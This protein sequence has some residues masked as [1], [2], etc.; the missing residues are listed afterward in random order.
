MTEMDRN[1]RTWYRSRCSVSVVERILHLTF[2]TCLISD[3]IESY[4]TL[5]YLLYLWLVCHLKQ[6]R[7]HVNGEWLKRTSKLS[8]Y[9]TGAPSIYVLTG[10]HF[11]AGASLH[12]LYGPVLS[13]AER[14][15]YTTSCITK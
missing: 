4:Q 2:H 7:I 6:G 10:S 8:T 15:S 11:D 1:D 14:T 5:E 3:D 9:A 12:R 13:E